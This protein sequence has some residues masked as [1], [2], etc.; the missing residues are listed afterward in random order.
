MAVPALIITDLPLL[1][2]RGLAAPCESAPFKFSHTQAERKYPYIDVSGHDHTGR[3]SIQF[4]VKLYFINSV[5]L[6]S[7]PQNWEAWLEALL[8]GKSG[9]LVHPVLGS[10]RARVLDGSVD[11]RAGVRGGVIV[12]VTFVETRDDVDEGLAFDALSLSPEAVAEQADLDMGLVGVDFPL[13][14]ALNATSCLDAY[15]KIKGQIFS[16]QLSITGAMNRLAGAVT[17]IIDDIDALDDPSAYP[18]RDN[19]VTFFNLLK[20][21]EKKLAKAAAR[22]TGEATTSSAT[23]LDAIAADTGNTLDEIMGLNVHLL[24]T[25]SVPAGATYRY[26]T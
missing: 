25:P 4:T 1:T 3:D 2:W 15:K 20:Q 6:D 11:V 12:D 19:L 26:Y 18:A 24:R 5:E 13:S 17:T 22:S 21:Q 10:L 9:E 8:D 23:T 7:F 14:N 16:A